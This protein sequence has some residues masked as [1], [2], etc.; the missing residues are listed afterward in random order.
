MSQQVVMTVQEWEQEIERCAV[1]RF[2]CKTGRV[3]SRGECAV[4][5]R[6]MEQ[7]GTHPKVF[8][9]EC[10]QF[11]RERNIPIPGRDVNAARQMPPV[12]TSSAALVSA[13]AAP[14]ATPVAAAAVEVVPSADNV[15]FAKVVL[16]IRE[17]EAYRKASASVAASSA[18][19]AD[20]R[21]RMH[22]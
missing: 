10:A 21:N 20:L 11:L 17:R 5:L 6:M 2:I 22:V 19:E 12:K 15:R 7:E 8:E 9:L 18:A 4:E 16:G 1:A 14:K 3:P 13:T